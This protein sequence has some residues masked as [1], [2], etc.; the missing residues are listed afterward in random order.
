[1][2]TGFGRQAAYLGTVAIAALAVTQSAGREASNAR[3]PAPI[4][5]LA[6]DNGV[7]VSARCDQATASLAHVAFSGR[8]S[9]IFLGYGVN[10]M[11]SKAA[12]DV[13][14][15]VGDVKKLGFVWVRMTLA[16]RADAGQG[17]DAEEA[18]DEAASQAEDAS[19]SPKARQL[20]LA[21]QAAGIKVVTWLGH[22][23]QSFFDAGGRANRKGKHGRRVRPEA[24][25]DL[26]QYYAATLQA[27]A[28]QGVHPDL[29]E[30]S[31]E[32]NLG[33]S[34]KFNPDEYAALMKGVQNAL[35]QRGVTARLAGPGTSARIGRDAE[36]VQAMQAQGALSG[37]KA[38]TIHNYY[39]RDRAKSPPVPAA[40][41]QAFQSM[42]AAARSAGIPM[43]SSEFGGS[44]LK[45]KDTDPSMESVNTAEEFK[46]ALDLMRAGDSAALVWAL[47]PNLSHG[48]MLYTWALIDDKGPTNAYWPFYIL[49]RKVPVGAEILA[50]DR[51][52]IAPGYGSPGYAAFR[53]GSRTYVG[54][55]NPSSGSPVTIALDMSR[56]GA[57]S[58]VHA[59]SFMP[60][61][62]VEQDTKIRPGSCPLTVTIP[63]GTGTVLDFE[64]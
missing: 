33:G 29:V 64:Q 41:D 38:I 3:Q 45:T 32:P 13:A 30:L 20:I 36:F 39:F 14:R 10:V 34:G 35:A 23:P 1:M 19:A 16:T 22:P 4:T 44:N 8:A 51:T 37:L 15:T 52:D 46:L 17:P 40:D 62:A 12:E 47:Y 49:A 57:Y 27:L 61:R 58:L 42:F 11:T 59:A 26:A 24:I 43:I 31:N 18:T 2:R 5:S 9:H 50:A 63:S 28:K 53:S 6:L 60:G 54:L 7:I 48:R 21:L 55:S 56:A 25:G